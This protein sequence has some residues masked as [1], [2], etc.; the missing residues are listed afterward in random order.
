MKKKSGEWIKAVTLKVCISGQLLTCPWFYLTRGLAH[1]ILLPAFGPLGIR[2]MF[3]GM[4][5]ILTQLLQKVP[6]SQL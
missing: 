1:R 5:D 2:D 4:S 3:D 6:S